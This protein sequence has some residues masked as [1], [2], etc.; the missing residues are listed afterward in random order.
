MKKE[1]NFSGKFVMTEP[2]CVIG[3]NLPGTSVLIKYWWKPNQHANICI[4]WRIFR[5]WSGIKLFSDINGQVYRR[6]EFALI[7]QFRGCNLG[8]P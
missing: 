6:N 2:L 4:L 5:I 3:K 7:G 1:K 8:L